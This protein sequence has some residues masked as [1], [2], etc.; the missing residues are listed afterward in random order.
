VN[1]A[2]VQSYIGSR[3]ESSATDFY[4]TPA[5]ATEA[6]F[7]KEQFGGEVWEP[8]SGNGSMSKVI[9][10]F[11]TCYSSDLRTDEAVYGDKG[12]NF[13]DASKTVANIITNPPFK[14]AL[15]FV[16]HSK[17][18]ATCKF[19]FI[20]RLSFLEGQKRKIMFE[21]TAFP[22]KSVYVFSKRIRFDAEGVV[23]NGKSG[24]LA[25]AWFVWDKSHAGPSTLGWI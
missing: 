22:L 2:Q 24:M 12:I 23:S 13:L 8:A 4:P 14:L 21:D 25:F 11:N 18:L 6:L 15:E 3:N 10:R 1:I 9:E 19:A 20:L 16:E 5:A 17:K 7:S